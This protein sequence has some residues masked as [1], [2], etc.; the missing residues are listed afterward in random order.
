[1]ISINTVY[2]F[3]GP[4]NLCIAK[5]DRTLIVNTN[6]FVFVNK[7]SRTILFDN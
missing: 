1:M 6:I 5:V 4:N 3:W 2:Y 7:I